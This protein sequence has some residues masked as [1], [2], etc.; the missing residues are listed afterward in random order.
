LILTCEKC[1]RRYSVAEEMLRSKP[2]KL[3]CKGCQ[4]ILVVPASSRAS[5]AAGRAAPRSTPAP[6]P[7]EQKKAKDPWPGLAAVVA[8]STGG[9]AWFAMI[10]GRQ[11]GP[12]GSAE[13]Q[14]RFRAGEIGP[15]TSLWREGMSEWQRAEALAEVA[16]LLKAALSDAEPT[17]DASRHRRESIED[18]T[19]IQERPLPALKLS[20][21]LL[22]TAVSAPR[23]PER[24]PAA[25]TE[26]NQRS[27]TEVSRRSTT[28]RSLRSTEPLAG[29][30]TRFFIEEAGM[31]KRNPLWKVAAFVA[32]L[33]VLPAAILYLLTTF[34]VGPL[35]VTRIDASG[36][37]V[38]ESVFSSDGSGLRDLLSGRGQASKPIASADARARS[39]GKPVPPL[40]KAAE[41]SNSAPRPGSPEP[42]NSPTRSASPELRAFYADGSHVD[43][44]PS[45]LK[46]GTPHPTNVES[47]GGLAEAAVAKVVAQT[48]PAFRFC[49]E[50][51]LKRNP[52]FKGGKIFINAVVGTSGTV[53]QVAISR[54]DIEASSL[55]ECL[56]SRARRMVFGSF[57][58]DDTELQIPLILT[59][60]L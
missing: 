15:R 45:R 40:P 36:K 57:S 17:E 9:S 33:I 31:H 2:V 32:S 34:K 28:E 27:T 54:P 49:I 22:A 24:E 46:P 39:T 51:E 7:Q 47:A 8:P 50:Q 16:P 41:P 56:K 60:S 23:E 29:E 10:K 25:S 21:D 35:I 53:K 26:V 14:T 48:Q 37:E 55:G 1:L 58:G 18:G 52:S 11:S 4:N 44:G 3:R 6:R 13:L 38:R 59:T 5:S 12:F 30:A 42:A 43:V 20:P 19:V